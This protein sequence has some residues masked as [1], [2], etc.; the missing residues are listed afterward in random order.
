MSPYRP[1]NQRRRSLSVSPLNIRDQHCIDLC[2][3]SVKRT[4]SRKDLPRQWDL[5]SWRCRKRPRTQQVSVRTNVCRLF[6][7]ALIFTSSLV[8]LLLIPPRG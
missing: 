4:R 7:A 8:S 2:L 6:E 1:T 5:D 3:P